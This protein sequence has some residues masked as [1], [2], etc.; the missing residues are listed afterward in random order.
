MRFPFLPDVLLEPPAEF[1]M[2]REQAP[3]ARVSLPTGDSAWLVTRLPAVRQVL[4]DPRL[5]RALTTVDGAPRLGPARPEPYSIMAMDPPD[6]TRLRRLVAPAFSSGRI[7]RLREGI[8]SVTASLL[9]AFVSPADVVAGLAQ[10]L[11]MAVICSMLGVP[12]ADQA[13]FREWTDTSLGLGIGQLEEVVGAREKLHDYLTDLVASKGSLLPVE[14]TP[15]EHVALGAT[16]ITAGYHTVSATIGNATLA[17]LRHPAQ[18]SLLRNDLSLLPQAVD[19]LLR[20]A[21]GPV[22][23]GTMRIAMEDLEIDGVLVRAGEAVIPSTSSANRDAAVFTDPDRLDLARSHNPHVA[24][25]PGIHHCLGSHLARVQ[26]QV[27]FGGLVSRFPGLRL[28]C[29]VS[30]LRWTNGMIR[31][32]VSLPVQW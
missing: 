4:A 6:H 29:D 11:P 12:V 14:A 26:L 27:A 5:S 13:Q 7:S 10:P 9:D 23:G 22:S 2:L 28:A 16:L 8:T 17:L 20:Y 25:G 3:V 32:L 19:E 18:M 30:E 31:G 1:A 24:F 15:A 21:P